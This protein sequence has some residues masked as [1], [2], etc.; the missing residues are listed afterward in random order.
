MCRG[1]K[2]VEVLRI[3]DGMMSIFYW[4]ISD[5]F[6][7]TLLF[8]DDGSRVNRIFRQDNSQLRRGGT[9]TMPGKDASS[10]QFILLFSIRKNRHRY[11]LQRNAACYVCLWVFRLLFV[12][13]IVGIRLTLEVRGDRVGV[14]RAGEGGGDDCTELALD[15]VS[16]AFGCCTKIW[17]LVSKRRC[18]SSKSTLN[19]SLFIVSR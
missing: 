1:E 12:K 2:I 9:S 18:N 13:P 16:M 5:T 4:T 11:V 14:R 19:F 3:V 17:H 8:T 7:Y 15:T 6:V 10:L